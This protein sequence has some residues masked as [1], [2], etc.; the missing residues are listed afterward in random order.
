MPNFFP[1]FLYWFIFPQGCIFLHNLYQSVG[2]MM[3]SHVTSK[4]FPSNE[5]EHLSYVNIHI[6]LQKDFTN[7]LSY[8][9][10]MRMP[11]CIV[12]T[13]ISTLV[14]EVYVKGFCPFFS[15]TCRSVL[16]ILDTTPLWVVLQSLFP[17]CGLSFHIV[18]DIL[19]FYYLQIYQF[20]T[21][22]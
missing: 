18:L 3:L 22:G 1:E 8:W 11:V 10:C 12:A 9:Q 16:C 2:C 20:F 7:W 19:T 14:S 13:W 5:A 6:V 21:Y 15:V 17:V 4:P